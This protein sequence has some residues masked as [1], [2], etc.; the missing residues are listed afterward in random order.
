MIVR[1]AAFVL[2]WEIMSSP[3][4]R[5]IWRSTLNVPVLKL[6]SSHWRARSSPRRRP[7]GDLQQEQ[8]VAT[9]LFGLDQQV[10]NLIRS[11]YL[12]FPG[13][14]RREP[15][16]VGRVAVDQL[17][18]DSHLQRRA[19]RGVTAP[20]RLVGETAAIVAGIL[21]SSVL[22]EVGVELLEVILREL[23]QR[24]VPQRGMM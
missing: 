6:R 7:G 16:S 10:L 9:V 13:L 14:G 23:V 22:L 20:H 11:E 19:E 5:W 8:L 24:G 3:M 18:G 15:A 17:L 1:L 12:H 4:A 2:G 21:D